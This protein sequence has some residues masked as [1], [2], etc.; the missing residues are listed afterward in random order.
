MFSDFKSN[1]ALYY[2]I[3]IGI[4][5]INQIRKTI[6]TPKELSQKTKQIFTNSVCSNTFVTKKYDTVINKR[7]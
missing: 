7:F 3:I 2:C 1:I 4:I 6:L 5:M